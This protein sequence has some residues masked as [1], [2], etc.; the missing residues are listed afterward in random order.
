MRYLCKTLVAVLFLAAF[1]SRAQ[2][3]TEEFYGTTEPF[4]AE[5]IYFVLTDRFA[6]GDPRNDQRGQGKD[7]G[8]S[9]WEGRLN[10]PDGQVDFIGYTGGDFK[11][12]YDNA[13]YIKDMG[14][15]AVWI[16]PIVDN[17]DGAFAGGSPAQF[18]SGVGADGGKSGYHGYW[19][20]NFYKVD[21][22]W[23]SPGFSFHEFT[24]KMRQDRG[25]KIVLDIVANHGSP[26]FT[27]PKNK[28]S[29]QAEE[30]F[31]RIYD[32]NGKLVADHRDLLPS[33]VD[34]PFF[35]KAV[36]PSPHCN[37]ECVGNL[38]QLSDLNENNPAVVDYLV[39]AYLK[40]IDQG[41]DAFRID[42]INWIPD[43]FWK[44][45][46]DRIRAAHP[47]FFMFGEHFSPH[48]NE[49]ARHQ[50][51]ANGGISV[52][53]FPG[54]D[55]ITSLFEKEEGSN[56]ADIQSYLHLT[57]GT[58]CHP[59]ELAT[60]YDNHDMARMNASKNGFIDA[61]N[62]LF[63]ARGIPVV[64]YGS[65][66][67]FMAG[68][69]EHEGNRNPYGTDN[70]ATARNGDIYKNLKQIAAIRKGS[71]A[72]QK[73][74]QANLQFQGQ[75]AAFYR[76]YQKDGVNQTALVLL[77]K[78]SSPASFKIDKFVSAGPWTDAATH[79]SITVAPENRVISSNVD[80]HGVKVLLFN[81][82]VND[83]TFIAQL[84]QDMKSTHRKCL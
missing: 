35:N 71:V 11:G 66:M 44:Q 70:M 75:T 26:S 15:T 23:E 81:D 14:F 61:H 68:K 19:G 49:I 46:S 37:S 74:L 45:F 31:G 48:A 54:K 32:E 7:C 9:D 4:A 51:P 64:Y 16:S 22:H 10:G 3:V 13:D 72:L 53:D 56:F 84:Q 12:I 33:Q 79:Q 36:D 38:A 1:S 30:G 5:A 82:K 50:L 18:G 57:D 21:E 67:G 69:K 29:C 40:W 65:E 42:T 58:Y 76:V 59:Y 52:L 62:W 28:Y 80:P 41:A 77:N 39:G 20:K 47:G 25:F 43:T 63:T 83:P 55:S 60:F 34:D 8:N 73:G 17:P 78:G 27:I 2:T 6:N 24:Q